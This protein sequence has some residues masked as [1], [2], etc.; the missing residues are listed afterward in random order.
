[1]I[2]FDYNA[3]ALGSIMANKNLEQDLVRHM[4][5]NT[6]RMYRQKFPKKDYGD[7]ILACDAPNNWRRE[8]FPQYKANRRKNRSESDFNWDEAFRILNETREE[9]RV[10]FPYKL[11]QVDGCEADDVIGTLAYN[12]QE[13]GQYENVVIISADHDF[14]QLQVL[15]NVKQFSP[16]AKKFVVE[17]NPRLKLLNHIFKGDPGDGVPNVLSDDNVF[18]EGIRQTPLSQKKMDGM[19]ADLD[20]GELLYA[21]SWYRNYQRNQRLVDLQ[22]TP[23]HLKAKILEEFEKQPQGKGSLILPYLINKKCKLLIE[24]ASEFS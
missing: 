5:L 3:I 12:T 6:L 4:I 17:K 18:V 7:V 13:F 21:A 19:I 8:V 20:D 9:I 15:D 22:Y 10:N 11:I 16:L 14:A 2:I 23:E 1:M 24:V